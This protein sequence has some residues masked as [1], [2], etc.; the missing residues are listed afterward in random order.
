MPQWRYVCFYPMNKKR[1][2]AE[3][4]FLLHFDERNR[5]MA[6]HGIGALLVMENGKPKIRPEEAVAL[7]PKEPARK[8]RRYVSRM[9]PVGNFRLP[10]A[11][12]WVDA[13][14]FEPLKMEFDF[15]GFGGKIT[16]LRTTKEA[17][18][19]AVTASSYWAGLAWYV[20]PAG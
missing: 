20:A 5:L 2:T 10:P 16:F 14:T 3:N 19:A 15:P 8:L 13:E 18:T 4:W 6:E 17:A 11:L 1:E 9:E 7:W 12:T